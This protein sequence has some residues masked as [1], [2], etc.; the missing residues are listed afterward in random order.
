MAW[1]ADFLSRFRPRPTPPP[2]RLEPFDAAEVVARMNAERAALGL[3]RLQQHPDL[4]N[5]A[6]HW[7]IQ[8]AAIDTL[9]HG[10]F[11]ARI[12]TKFPNT[13][14]GEV[15][16]AGQVSAKEVVDS[17]MSSPGHRAQILGSAYGSVGVGREVS[18][19][20]VPYWCADFA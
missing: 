20:R 19:S 13:L 6:Q 3:T 9:S 7:A 1:L 15:I 18:A 2:A 10:D 11:H 12:V 8:M 17:W 4:T 5:L 14:A 16:A